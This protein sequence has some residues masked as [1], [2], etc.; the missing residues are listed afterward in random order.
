MSIGV[1]CRDADA[2]T[3]ASVLKLADERLY[4]AKQSGRNRVV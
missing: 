3:A 2:A 1:A 4:A